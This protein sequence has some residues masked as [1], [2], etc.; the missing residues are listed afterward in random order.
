M[1]LS[2]RPVAV[3]VP[4]SAD[5]RPAAQCE[6]PKLVQPAAAACDAKKNEWT[7]ATH[8]RIYYTSMIAWH[9]AG[10]KYIINIQ[11]IC[12]QDIRLGHNILYLFV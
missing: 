10:A 2:S 3:A 7:E 5:R 11:M 12:D 8:G 9:L 4:P 6:L 1:S